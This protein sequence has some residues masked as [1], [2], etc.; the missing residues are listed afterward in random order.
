MASGARTVNGEHVVADHGLVVPAS[1]AD[2]LRLLSRADWL[3]AE[4]AA[5]IAGAA[6]LRNV[7]VHDDAEVDDR[8]VVADLERVEE[9]RRFV[10]AVRC[11]PETPESPADP[12]NPS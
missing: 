5:A 1:N 7:L 8:R 9:L 12:A 3:H 6:G 2:A 4:L 10:A 11:L